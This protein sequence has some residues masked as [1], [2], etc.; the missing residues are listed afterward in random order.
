MKETMKLLWVIV[1]IALV[2]PTTTLD[3]QTLLDDSSSGARAG[4][5]L[6]PPSRLPRGG[7]R[8]WL[9]MTPPPPL[10]YEL[11]P[12]DIRTTRFEVHLPSAPIQADILFAFDTTG[13]M[14]NV[15]ETAQ[16]R[17]VE[18]MSNLQALV[19]DVRFGVIDFRD[20][21]YDPYG[22]S[23]DWPYR[24]RQP[25][26]DHAPYVQMKIEELEGEGGVDGPEAYARVFYE[27]Y[28]DEHI[29]WRPEARRFI[30]VF[31]DSVPHDDDLNAGI[32][33][34]QPHLEYEMWRTGYPPA[35][36]D[37]GRDAEGGTADD[38]DFQPVLGALRDHSITLLFIVSDARL[39]GLRADDLLVYWQTW[40]AMTGSGGDARVLEDLDDLP[41]TIQSL[42]TAAV[43]HLDR[44]TVSVAPSW[45]EEWVTIVPSAYEDVNIPADGLYRDFEVII[46][47]PPSVPADHYIFDL[48]VEADGTVYQRQRV[49]IT[50]PTRCF[51]TP[52][53]TWVP[54]PRPKPRW[55]LFIPFI[56]N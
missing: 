27:A 35:Y 43:R 21:P 44:L 52:T 23:V 48:I 3:L 22:Q 49:E 42:V 30:I 47:V 11:C 37:P 26:T 56:A 5:A 31:G 40:A 17:A 24:L 12:G 32:P 4:N 15:I 34:P 38:L 16:E 6:D 50:V 19:S 7:S 46:T 13:S 1:T 20:Y 54:L 29:G 10:Q 28:A 51:A 36:I 9:Q 39:E 53:P 14:N 2:A 33:A 55:M 18:I 25:L 41:A 8:R 45:F